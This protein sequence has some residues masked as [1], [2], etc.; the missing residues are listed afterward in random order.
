MGGGTLANPWHW[1][2]GLDAN[3]KLIGVDVTWN[4]ATR[5]LVSATAHRDTGCLYTKIF[6]GL[7]PDGIPNTSPEVFDLT[8]FTGSKTF[9]AAQMASVGLHTIDDIISTQ[10]TAGT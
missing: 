10:I 5:A 8:G 2:S 7:G 3:G 4:S 6:I 9:S 1:D